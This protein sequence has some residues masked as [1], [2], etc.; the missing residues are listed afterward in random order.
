MR[1]GIAL[2]A[3]TPRGKALAEYLAAKLGGAV[4]AEETLAVWTRAAFNAREALI[5]IGAAGIAV[6]SIAPYIRS[7]AEDPAVLCVDET[8]RW[9]IPIL[10]GHLGGANALALR[11]ASLTGGAAVITTATDLN[12]LFAVDLWAKAQNMAVLQP[13]RIRN[14]SAKLLRDEDIVIDCPYPV[15]GSIPGHV[16]LG[17]PGD[18]LV[19]YRQTDSGALQLVPRVLTLGIGCKRGTSTETLNEAFQTFC[20][21]RGI[22]PKA[23][24][25]AA[26]IDLKQ[27][28]AGLLAFCKAHD[29]PLRFYS[30]EEL[31]DI[32]G[33]FTASVFVESV[34]GV[35]NVCERAAALDAGGRLIERK[36]ACGAAT[37]AAAE[38]YVNYDWSWQ[39]G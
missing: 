16:R 32:E 26:S 37:F 30:A 38:R 11:V 12:G 18:V 14:V 21:E 2:T 4:R 36:Y 31:R 20:T 39:D 9:V 7:K 27:D 28:E 23:F 17:T 13:E 5:Y 19:S 8:G 15:T 35:D 3:F 29:W 10:S 25:G 33:V 24:T 34:T 1:E 22:L 6:R